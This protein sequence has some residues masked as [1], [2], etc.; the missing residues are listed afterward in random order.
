[1]PSFYLGCDWI[2]VTGRPPHLRLATGLKRGGLRMPSFDDYRIVILQQVAGR[3]WANEIARL[4]KQGVVVL[5]EIDD[6]LHS[7]RKIPSHAFRSEF[8]SKLVQE[9][10]LCM[11]MSSGLICSTDWLA[12]SYRKFN[13]NVYICENSIEGKRYSPYN[14][15]ERL[16]GTVNIG[17]AGGNGHQEA[18]QR[19]LPA[20]E[21][22]LEDH[23]ETRFL[24][25]GLP[26]ADLLNKPKQAFAL[27][28]VP[29]ENFP[30][31]L[32]NFDI[33]IAPS[34]RSNFY[35][36]KSELR[37]LELGGLG[38]PGVYDPFV[39]GSV[40]DGE[41]GLLAETSEDAEEALRRL[42]V[43]PEK[44]LA[45]GIAAREHVHATSTIEKGVEQ[46]ERVFTS[47][48]LGK[49]AV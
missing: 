43:A 40:R 45:I 12:K 39:Y 9:H 2:A 41:T 29:V 46:W 22:I 42:L 17:W 13:P 24:S 26:V 38:I 30:G 5:Y 48:P 15:P 34:G 1:M 11:R 25:V 49:V 18:V 8:T 16:G 32:C 33:G 7:I 21:N 35:R 20:I 36:A 28:A 23:P 14:R 44:A 31:V 19:W 37:Y 3:E 6:H 47:V 10:E 27:P 4:K